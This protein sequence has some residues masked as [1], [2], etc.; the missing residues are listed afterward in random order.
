VAADPR[1]DRRGGTPDRGLLI[2]TRGL[3]IADV[4]HFSFTVSDIERSVD[5]YT[6]V[7]G[8]GLVHRQRQEND[9]TPILVGIPGAVL[10][11][12]QFA[13]P[14]VPPAR[15]TH[16]LEL[17]EYVRPRRRGFAESATNAVGCA[18]LALLVTDIHARHERMLA[19]GV[20]FHNPPVAITA[21]AN[22]GGFACYF[23][24]PDGITL[25]LLQPSR[26]QLEA[27]GLG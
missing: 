14:G 9:Y 22:A 24:D 7:L 13:V 2:A 3:M 17:V 5:W 26:Q 4:L 23:R 15:S 11:V 16:M 19:Q 27:L 6:R 1:A 12:A 21:G 20:V 10:E 18:H 25:E 8:L